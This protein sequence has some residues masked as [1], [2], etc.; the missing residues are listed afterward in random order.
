MKEPRPVLDDL[1]LRQREPAVFGGSPWRGR[2]LWTGLA[3]MGA[4]LLGW[5][6]ALAVGLDPAGLAGP[7]LTLVRHAHPASL[8]HH[9][10]VVV[11]A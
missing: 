3:L 1:P 6:W 11:H 2:L 10:R 9:A 8:V 5:G 7:A 4:V